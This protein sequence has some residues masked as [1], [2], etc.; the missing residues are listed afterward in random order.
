MRSI[1]HQWENMGTRLDLLLKAQC[2]S[3][4]NAIKITRQGFHYP[5]PRFKKWRQD[6][7]LQIL[8]Q[9]GVIQPIDFP[10]KATIRYTP[11]DKIR[12]DATGIMDALWH[13]FEWAKIITDD[14][15]IQQVDYQQMPLDRDNPNAK[16]TLERL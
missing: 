10:V 7:T 12:R 15:L 11:G 8:G 6:M 3:G 2:P 16:I 4:K 1:H 14:A 9:L 5:S 13:V